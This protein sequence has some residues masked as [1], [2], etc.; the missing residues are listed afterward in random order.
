MK[1]Q[2]YKSMNLR[3]LL[4]LVFVLILS[5]CEKETVTNEQDLETNLQ[6]E[7]AIEAFSFYELSQQNNFNTAIENFGI[8]DILIGAN[9]SLLKSSQT[10][11]SIDTEKI[12]E[13]KK[14]NYTSFTFR[15][16]NQNGDDNILDN[17][18]IEQRNDTLQ[19]F[20]IKYRYSQHYL[21]QLEKGIEI[22][23]EGTVQRTHY[24]ENIEELFDIINTSK[25]SNMEKSASMLSEYVCVTTTLIG[26]KRCDSKYRHRVGENCALTGS[27]RASYYTYTVTN[28]WD[29]PTGW[30]G[31]QEVIDYIAVDDFG[32]GG[33]STT[34][35]VPTCS[36]CNDNTLAH[37]ISTRLDLFAEEE[38]WLEGQGEDPFVEDL[39]FFL[40]NNN[41]LEAKQFAREIVNLIESDNQIDNQAFNFVIEAFDQNKIY[42]SFDEAFINSVDQYMATPGIDAIQLQI[43]FSTQCAVL[44]YNHPNWS[45]TK[46]YWEASKDIVHITLDVFGMI[47]V[48]GEIADLT[49]GVLY[50]I[51]GDGLNATLSFAATIPVAGWAAT[52]TKYAVKVVNATTIGTKVRLTWKVLS[53]GAIYFGSSGNKLRKAL[54]ITDSAIHAHH[55]IPWAKKDLLIIQKAA[56]SKNAF[57]MNEALNGIPMPNDLHLTGHS[58]YSAKIDEILINNFD[59][60]MTPNE[61]YDFVT[62]LASHIRDLI[63][64][65]PTL[66]S[67]QIANLI[68]YP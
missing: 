63:T 7:N 32:G 17:L 24:N 51:E 64:N 20:L 13:I 30:S 36:N 31:E 59:V 34:P 21:D 4:L 3:T 23:F 57:H 56:K 65:N 2:N 12:I 58:V 35:N 50:T 19:G 67:G 28:C 62:G 66:N 44:R 15:I 29:L 5:N 42:N 45:D 53:D 27:H 11:I 47:P 16:I 39:Y 10:G 6:Q 9:G 18:V 40:E 68:S 37:M 61:A 38:Q 1:K 22:P 60:N 26:E 8:K 55:L 48:V 33:T 43:Y 52:G 49:N 46:I 14:E 41:S 25:S 54:G